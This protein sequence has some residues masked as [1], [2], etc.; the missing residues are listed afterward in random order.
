MV[1]LDA[2]GNYADYDPVT[3]RATQ[4]QVVFFD[5]RAITVQKLSPE[6]IRKYISGLTIEDTSRVSSINCSKPLQSRT[7]ICQPAVH[8][9]DVNV[10]VKIGILL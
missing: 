9:V 7:H 1:D 2:H 8:S 6:C 5:S 4:Y 3:H 10:E